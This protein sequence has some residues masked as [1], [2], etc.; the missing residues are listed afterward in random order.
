MATALTASCTLSTVSCGQSAT[1]GAQNEVRGLYKAV[2]ADGR[3]HHFAAICDQ[4]WSGLLKQL[5]YLFKINC[6]KALAAEWAEGVHLTRVGPGTRITV[7]GKTATVFDGSSPE[8]AVFEQGRWKLLEFPRNYR[9]DRRNEALEVAKELNPEFRKE[10][11]PELNAETR[12]PG[13]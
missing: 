1:S 12:G 11:L 3:D 9:H 7:A 4:Y 13:E 2:A 5:D 6:P 8:R 10:H